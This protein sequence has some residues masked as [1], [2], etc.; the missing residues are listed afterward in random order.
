MIQYGAANVWDSGDFTMTAVRNSLAAAAFAV[1]ALAG[2]SDANATTYVVDAFANSSSGGTG[3]S[4]IALTLGETFHVTA[5]PNDLWSA[6][7]LP[8]WSD[9][10]GLT[11]NRFATGTDESL[12]PINTLIGIDFGLW[13]QN[14]LSAPFGTLVGEIGGVYQ[15][16]GTNFNGL[17]WGTGTL[18]LYYWDSNFGDNTGSIAAQVSA[19]PEPAAWTMLLMGFGGL[20]ALLRF[21]RRTDFAVAKAA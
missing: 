17:A 10:D 2:I 8:R 13:T 14:G 16:L 11:G 3:L 19:A 6:G 7:A 5:S 9:A 15:P 21:R 12:Q 1:A 20:G 18:N 4:T